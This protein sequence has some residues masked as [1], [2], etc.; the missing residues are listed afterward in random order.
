[1]AIDFSLSP[2]LEDIRLQIRT[3]VD[4]VIKPEEERLEGTGDKYG[5]DEPLAGRERIDAL[6]GLLLLQHF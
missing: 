6:I 4:D 1:M 3:F 2:E 5:G